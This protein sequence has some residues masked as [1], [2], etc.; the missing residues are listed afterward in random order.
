MGL[1]FNPDA[2]ARVY[3]RIDRIIRI[4]QEVLALRTER[5]RLVREN[6][7]DEW[8]AQGKRWRGS[9]VSFSE[10]RNNMRFRIKHQ[11]TTHVA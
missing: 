10:Y 9:V 8:L 3:R 4:D 6:E 11:P 7:G 5:Q 2:S 1:S